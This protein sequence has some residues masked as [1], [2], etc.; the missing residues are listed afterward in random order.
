[1]AGQRPTKPDPHGR[2]LDAAERVFATLG[3]DGASLRHI[4]GD[5]KVNLPTVYY[6]FGSKKGLFLAVFNRRFEPVRDAHL[7]LLRQLDQDAAGHPLPVETIMDALVTPVLRL[8]TP[9]TAKS[10]TIVQ[11]MGRI[12]TDPSPNMQALFHS[13]H[14]EVRSKFLELLQ[15][16]LPE[17]PPLDLAWRF[18][19]AM[20]S[21]AFTLCNPSRIPPEGKPPAAALDIQTVRAQMIGFFASGFRAPAVS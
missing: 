10:L 15:Q 6:H 14:K 8:M 7:L 18:H 17:L 16:S 2:I 13:L 19:L 4:V 5:A 3:F 9:A 1:M 11:L 20:G 12:I 21:L